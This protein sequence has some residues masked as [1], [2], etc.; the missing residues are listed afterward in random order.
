MKKLCLL[1]VAV[2]L[3]LVLS[4]T[5]MGED[6]V[7]PPWV[8]DPT[9]PQWDGGSTTFQVWEFA[10]DPYSDPYY[11][12]EWGPPEVI[13]T[14]AT[15]QIAPGPFLDDTTGEPIDIWT[16]HIDGTGGID[17]IVQNDPRPN[18]MKIIWVQITADKAPGPTSPSSNPSGTT[19]YPV[20]AWQHPNLPWYT[21]TARIDIPYN[22]EF[23]IIHYDFPE[24]TNISEIVVDTICIPEPATLSLLVLGGLVMLRR[25][26]R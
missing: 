18:D 7:P 23:E 22:P 26:R 5:V 11:E 12:N 20:P 10:Q 14:N 25:R 17:I 16:W 13:F 6:V 15:P 1:M 3:M 21:F 8:T 24:S 4:Q 2:G 19:T 9:D